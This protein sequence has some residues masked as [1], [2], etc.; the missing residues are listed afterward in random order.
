MRITNKAGLPS[1]IVEA[2]QNDSYSPGSS[3]ITV[4]QLIDPPR[5]VELRRQ[6]QGELVED[7]ADRIYA[8]L[9]QSIHTIL[10]RAEASALV[11][12]RLYAEV[13]GWTIGGQFDRLMLIDGLL[14]D[15]KLCSV[16]EVI[17]GLKPEREQ[18]LNILRY[19]CE[20][21]GYEVGQL[22]AVAIFRDWSKSKA[23]Y[24]AS[25]PDQQVQRIPVRLWSMSETQDFIR[26]RV[27]AHKAA[28]DGDLPDCTPD[29]RWLRGEKYAVMK[30]G[31]KSAVRLFDTHK[32]AESRLE[33]LKGDYI[34]H[35]PGQNIRCEN[36]CPVA[37]FCSQYQAIKEQS[38]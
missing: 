12:D 14:Q 23:Q 24:D 3:D 21:N 32:E 2:V 26:E 29:E 31:R 30:K 17:N 9:G 37:D 36:Y 18:Q 19:L 22:E 20:A 10:E 28:R 7:A 33:D 6:H 13:D 25:Y 11:E 8:L 34:D 1:A 27:R 38:Q 15:Y 4:T 5:L 16:W 35:R